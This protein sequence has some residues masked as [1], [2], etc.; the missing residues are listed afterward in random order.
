L[1]GYLSLTVFPYLNN[2][3]GTGINA[4]AMKPNMVFPHPRP[5][6]AYMLGPARG[7]MAP[8][9][10]RRHVMPAMALAAYCGKQSIM[11]VC[12]GAKM[13]MTPKPKGTREMMGTGAC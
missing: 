8:K 10:Q 5:R 6:V 9:R 7:S 3:A 1:I 4:I 11:Y 13:P 2:S 12:R